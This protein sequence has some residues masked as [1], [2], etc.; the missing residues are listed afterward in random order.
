MVRPDRGVIFFQLLIFNQDILAV[1]VFIPF[2]HFRAF[3][4]A[5]ARGA[6]K[7]LAQARFAFLMNL[8]EIHALAARRGEQT[9]WNGQ[10]AKAERTF[11]HGMSHWMPPCRI[12]RRQLEMVRREFPR[13]NKVNH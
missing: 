3:H 7:G 4:I 8:V 12:Q 10:Q 2:N 5:F 6:I 9:N 13:T 1:V 11:P